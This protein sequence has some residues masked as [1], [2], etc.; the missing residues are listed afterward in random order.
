MRGRPVVFLTF[1]H[2]YKIEIPNQQLSFMTGV[3]PQHFTPG[4]LIPIL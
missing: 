2:L 1:Y 3:C 4:T